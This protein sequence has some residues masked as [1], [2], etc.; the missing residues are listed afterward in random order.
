MA[1][2]QVHYYNTLVNKL[3]RGAVADAFDVS[4]A[5]ISTGGLCVDTLL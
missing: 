1:G 5:V 2:I 4:I 3:H